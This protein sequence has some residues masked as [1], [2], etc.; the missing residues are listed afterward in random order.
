MRSPAS[1]ITSRVSASSSTAPYAASP[2]LPR[3][4]PSASI[5]TDRCVNSDPG[6]RGA[7][8]DPV[9]LLA[10]QH[11]VERRLGD[12]PEVGGG[13]LQAAALA[14]P[15]P[16]RRGTHAALLRADL[17][18]ER[19]QVR[20]HAVGDLLALGGHLAGLLGDL[21]GAGVAAGLELGGAR[22]DRD[23]PLGEAGVL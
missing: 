10:A 16:Q 22:V 18:V 23:E 20:G 5:W 9:A 21:A 4:P 11:L 8:Q 2:G 13:E 17:L 1:A 19:E 14:A 7:D 6:L 15:G 3:E 12:R